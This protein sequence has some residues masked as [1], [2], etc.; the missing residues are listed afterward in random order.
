MVTRSIAFV[1]IALSCLTA[2]GADLQF[3]PK[4][5]AY[6]LEGIK[7]KQLVF[8]D[9]TNKAITYAA[10]PGWEYSGSTTKLT[11]HPSKKPQAQGI[12]SKVNLNQPAVFDAVT[13][14]KLTE[15]ALTSVPQGSTNVAVISQEK[16]PLFINR[17]ETFLVT[18]S[19]RFYGERYERSMMFLNRG[20]EQIRFQLVSRA[21]D[22]KDLQRAFLGSHCS[23]Q[24]L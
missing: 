6:E 18:I 19:Y 21:S 16:N 10:P 4:E 5:S 22:F 12:F 13:T 20:N 1:I 14:K 3:T 17:K 7:F 23:W 15:E 11:L 24:N 2:A 8:S 9:G